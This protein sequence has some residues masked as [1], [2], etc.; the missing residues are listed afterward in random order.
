[1]A[2]KDWGDTTASAQKNGSAGS[3]KLMNGSA[4]NAYRVNGSSFTL[5]TIYKVGTTAPNKT[6]M[7]IYSQVPNNSQNNGTLQGHM[8]HTRRWDGGFADQILFDDGFGGPST[9]WQQ[10][11]SGVPEQ[12]PNNWYAMVLRST[13]GGGTSFYRFD[14][15]DANVSSITAYNHKTLTNTDVEWYANTN[16]LMFLNR[17]VQHTRKTGDRLTVE[18]TKYWAKINGGTQS[19]SMFRSTTFFGSLLTDAQIERHIYKIMTGAGQN[20]D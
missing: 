3:A 11:N 9:Q 7:F 2:Y 6:R 4:L 14:I 10:R 12:S 5:I 8:Y 1:M 20:I 18:G 13:K 15:A 19:S 16:L 17:T